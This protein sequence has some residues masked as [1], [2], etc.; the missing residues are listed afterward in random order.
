MDKITDLIKAEL[1]ESPS[2][3][4]DKTHKR[5][6]IRT[7]YELKRV[8]PQ[9]NERIRLT[10]SVSSDDRIVEEDIIAK[11]VILAIPK[12]PLQRVLIASAPFIP[13]DVR[14]AAD[15]VFEFPM[16][17]VFVVVRE[18]WWE[19]EHRANLYATRLPTREL[20]YFKSRDQTSRRGMIM[21]Y[22]DRPS[23]SFWA[24]YV[25]E[26]GYQLE[27]EWEAVDSKTFCH[28]KTE[29]KDVQTRRLIRKLVA[30]FREM[31]IAIGESD[32][33]HYGIRDWGRL[34]Y[35]GANHAWRPER[36]SWEELRTLS[37]FALQDAAGSKL[38]CGN[39]HVCGEAYSD[40]HGFIEGSLRSA[41]HVLHRLDENHVLTF[42]KDGKERIR[43][44]TPWLCICTLCCDDCRARQEGRRTH[45]TST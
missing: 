43:T 27:P 26:P 18:R 13:K 12:V 44:P 6:Q 35:G 31:D 11:R 40:Y 37:Q 28:S 4:N 10:F 7:R 24:N 19:E 15:S 25:R 45:Y 30:Y 5:V 42:R 17:K 14:D 22:A 20:H 38:K 32:I 34:P 33:E 3:E 9:G 1:T 16:T 36:R 41:A 8:R 23:S 29:L 21:A 39:M 2:Q